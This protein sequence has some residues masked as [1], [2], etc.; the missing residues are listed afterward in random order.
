MKA[1]HGTT[2]GLTSAALAACAALL[3]SSAPGAFAQEGPIRIGII[4]PVTGPLATPGIEA[5]NGFTQ[6]F[7]EIGNKVAG[8]AVVFV[9]EDEAG[10]P[11][12]G[13]ERVRRLV[14]REQVHIVTGIT[15]SAVAYAVRDYIHEKQVPLVI[16]GSAGAN[17]MT[18]ER[19]SPYIF[20]TSF[21]NRQ[22]N[23][24]FG[25]YAC[26]K[27]GYK[28]VVVMAS[29]FVTGHEQSAAFEETFK[30]SGCEVVKKILAPLGTADFAP[31][32]SQIPSSGVD[33]VWAMFIGSDAIAFVKQY[34]QLGLKARIPLIA[35]SAM[36][37]EPLLPAMGR[38]ALGIVTAVWYS[39]DFPGEVNQ[40]F[41]KNFT[42]QYKTVPGSATTGAY[43]GA[44]AIVAA[45]EA[46]KGKV[47]DKAAF[48]AA[49]RKVN[50]PV[51]PQGPFRFDDKQNVVF[52]LTAARIAERG[53]AIVPQ[54]IEKIATGVDQNWQPR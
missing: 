9:K 4:H 30:K 37:Y 36:T 7:N 22:L 34:D 35:S 18:G 20:R 3:L 46:V 1:N 52:D 44:M 31:F 32:L 21:T 33:A 24:A 26:N 38:S 47:E 8:R 50:L 42:A 10:N 5:T 28:R 15:S 39:V 16:M 29:D 25:P 11:A 23:A 53:G 48:L 27:L 13:L 6:Y 41:V 2:T 17:G 40:R 49:L 14:E 54:V 43:V 12:Q 51:T 45:L 19:G